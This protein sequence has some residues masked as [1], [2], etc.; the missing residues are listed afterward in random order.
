[1][2]RGEI[3]PLSLNILIL[4]L[5]LHPTIHSSPPYFS[6]YPGC[7]S[8][9]FFFFSFSRFGKN[10]KNLRRLTNIVSCFP[11]DK[12]FFSPLSFWNKRKDIRN[13]YYGQR[14]AYQRGFC[15]HLNNVN[16]GLWSWILAYIVP[17]A[18]YIVRLDPWIWS[19]IT[20]SNIFLQNC[21]PTRFVFFMVSFWTTFVFYGNDKS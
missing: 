6:V 11:P 9:H 17:I 21:C 19:H 12:D 3:L 18:V 15:S 4:L 5:L 2:K 13:S 16:R 10:Y 20:S 7:V 14:K 1:M 8:Y